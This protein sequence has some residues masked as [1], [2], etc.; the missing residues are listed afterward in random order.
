VKAIFAEENLAY[1]IDEVGGIHPA[2]DHEFQRNIVSA[3]AA[4]Q[5]QRYRNVRDAF[6]S[7]SNHLSADPPNYKQAWRGTFAAVG[8]LFGLMFPHVRLTVDEVDRRRGRT[9]ADREKTRNDGRPHAPGPRATKPATSSSVWR[10]DT[11]G[12]A[13]PVACRDWE[14]AL[15]DARWRARIRGTQAV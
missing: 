13:M 2:V 11:V 9:T 14:K 5:S 7:A 12:K 1:Q 8:L 4:L 15:P 3:I 6:E 10:Q